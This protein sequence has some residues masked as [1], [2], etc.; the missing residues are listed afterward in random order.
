MSAQP[1]LYKIML[2]L[3]PRENHPHLDI[4]F[5]WFLGN[6]PAGGALCA[7]WCVLEQRDD[8]SRAHPHRSNA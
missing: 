8:E 4:A 7:S 5:P 6:Q 1:P 3:C 2:Y